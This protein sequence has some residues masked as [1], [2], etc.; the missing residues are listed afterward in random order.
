MPPDKTATDELCRSI[1]RGARIV[2]I[3][4]STYAV[5]LQLPRGNLETVYPRALVLAGIRQHLDE[6]DFRAAYLACVNHQV[7]LNIICDYKPALLMEHVAAFV[8]QVDKADRIDLFLSKLSED[9]VSQTLYKDT[10]DKGSDG[11][12]PHSLYWPYSTNSNTSAE[13]EAQGKVNKI[14]NRFLSILKPRIASRLQNVVT[15]YVCKRPPDL[16]SALELIG[17]LRKDHSPKAE[18]AVSHLCFLSDVN[19]LYDTALSL[20]DLPLTLLIAQLAQRDPREYMPFLESLNAAPPL[21]RH[22]RI[23]DHL[24]NYEK[25]LTSLHTL[26]AHDEVEQYTI[27]HSLFSQAIRLYRHDRENLINIT[28]HHAGYLT[29]QSDH[30]GA[31]IA[32]ESLT[33]HQGALTS[34]S[35]CSP[36]RWREA[37]HCAFM[38]DPPLSKEDMHSLA[39]KLASALTDIERDYRPAAQ[40]HIDYLHDIPTA[41]Q[42]LCKGCYFAEALRLLSFHKLASQIPAIV[43]PAL[44][45]KSGEITE[46]ITDC[47][48]Q[49]SAQVP[50][51]KELRIKKAQDPLGFFGGDAGG[52]ADNEAGVH[53][54]S[55]NVS[56]APT[57]VTSTLGGQSLFT[58]YGNASNASTGFSGTTRKT[59]KTRR[60][61]ERKRARGKKGSIYEEEYLVNSVRRLIEKVN[62]VH[63]EVQRLVEGLARR[64]VLVDGEAEAADRAVGIANADRRDVVEEMMTTMVNECDR[65]VKEVWGPPSDG[66]HQLQHQING[67]EDNP[68]HSRIAPVGIVNQQHP[69]P[70]PGSSSYPAVMTTPMAPSHVMPSPSSTRPKGADGVLWQSQMETQLVAANYYRHR[71]HPASQQPGAEEMGS[72]SNSISSRSNSSTVEVP[73]VRPWKK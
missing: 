55:D 11:N 31:A 63:S 7:D 27:R 66:A 38:I 48:L 9:D 56:L 72:S 40:I 26:A 1:E 70:H 33:D 4:P 50:R 37:L 46:L 6:K 71:H 8:D 68:D 47:R 51:V 54:T 13:D 57:D 12:V 28:R 62:S 49:L 42:L 59:S 29:S 61:E 2:T 53:D 64:T 16:V 14:C 60:K 35:K 21:Q 22:F 43:D 24:H 69:S 58:R 3:I 41:A 73:K 34:Y 36:P 39:L 20:Y 19:R 52:G 45:K 10:L 65:A 44:A 67:N 15:A 18:E 32:L 30:L 25:A 17:S 5:V 23:D